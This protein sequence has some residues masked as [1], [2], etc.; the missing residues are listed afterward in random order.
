MSFPAKCFLG[1]AAII[2]GAVALF[3]FLNWIAP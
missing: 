1:G 2:V 3:A